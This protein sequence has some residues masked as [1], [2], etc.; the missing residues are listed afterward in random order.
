MEVNV[1]LDMITEAPKVRSNDDHLREKEDHSQVDSLGK[2]DPLTSNFSIKSSNSIF[3]NG[4]KGTRIPLLNQ[5]IVYF[6]VGIRELGIHPS[7]LLGCPN[8]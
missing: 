7:V 2:L 1:N 5:V 4:D 3:Y 8:P 6:I